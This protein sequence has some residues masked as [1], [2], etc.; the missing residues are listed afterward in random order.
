[1]QRRATPASATIRHGLPIAGARATIHVRATTTRVGAMGVIAAATRER[2]DTRTAA[3]QRAWRRVARAAASRRVCRHRIANRARNRRAHP[4]QLMAS[5]R[6]QR[7]LRPRP[8]RLRARGSRSNV[9]AIIARTSRAPSCGRAA[10]LHPS[11]RR[12]C[13]GLGRVPGIF[14]A[15]TAFHTFRRDVPLEARSHSQLLHRRAHRSR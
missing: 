2:V 3:S 10:F 12:L 14:D 4:R 7:L 9:V 8:D 15:P 6:G 11:P 1:V 13:G 5:R